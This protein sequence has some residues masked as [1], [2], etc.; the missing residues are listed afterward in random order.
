MRFF[1]NVFS[2]EIFFE[3]L[4][5]WSAEQCCR[6]CS[7]AHHAIKKISNPST[8]WKTRLW[9]KLE[10]DSHWSFHFPITVWLLICC[11]IDALLSWGKRI[12]TCVQKQT[13]S[14]GAKKP[15]SRCR[16]RGEFTIEIVSWSGFSFRPAN[17][18]P[19]LVQVLK[20]DLS[21]LKIQ[22][23]AERS[24]DKCWMLQDSI[25]TQC[26]DLSW[27]FFNTKI[28]NFWRRPFVREILSPNSNLD[29]Y[30]SPE[31]AGRW[32]SGMQ[33]DALYFFVLKQRKRRVK[34]G[35][36]FRKSGKRM[37]SAVAYW[38]GGEVALDIHPMHWIPHNL[39]FLVYSERISTT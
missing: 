38:N 5:L 27:V 9:S 26:D 2:R 12:P 22:R 28:P 10:Q 29:L 31:A 11:W 18:T 25:Q 24:P 34:H 17:L 19:V 30:S 37:D 23:T 13:S 15:V 21:G 36:M 3:P 35:K 8:F 32:L 33:I 16:T 20:A 7:A 6:G 39:K 4:G 1:L 14:L